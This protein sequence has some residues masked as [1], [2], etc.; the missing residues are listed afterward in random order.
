[1][2][3][4]L[5]AE[6]RLTTK[7]SFLLDPVVGCFAGNHDIVHVAFSQ[8][9]AAYANETCL[10]LQVQ[11]TFSAA[12]AHTRTQSTNQLIDRGRQGAAIRHATFNSFRHKFVQPVLV[13]I[14][15]L[16][17]LRGAG[18]VVLALGITLATACRH[19]RERSH[20]AIRLERA[21]LIKDGLA[22]TLVGASE[23]RPHHHYAC[24]G[25][26]R[27]GNSAG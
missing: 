5:I 8:S 23:K 26:E 4:G 14:A 22:L 21:S 25:S 7:K 3:G 20:A 15:F 13:A 9:R 1:M 12:I 10:L 18:E 6:F 16:H 24:S 27:L 11:D 17:G 19:G 2:S